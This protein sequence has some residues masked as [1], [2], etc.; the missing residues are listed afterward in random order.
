M[1]LSRNKWLFII[2]LLFSISQLPFLSRNIVSWDESVYLGI[3][4]YIYSSGSSGLWEPIRPLGLPVITGLIWKLGLPY[5]LFSQFMAFIFALASVA[6]LY[7]IAEKLFSKNVAVLAAALLVATPVFFTNSHMILTE[8]PSSFFVLLALYAFICN[9]H[10]QCGA[11]ASLAM[12]FKFTGGLVVIALFLVALHFMKPLSRN[13]RRLIPF[14]KVAVSFLAVTLP[15]MVFNS[16]F[17]HNI[18]GNL[19]NAALRPFMGNLR[20]PGESGIPRHRFANRFFGRQYL[21]SCRVE[22]TDNVYGPAE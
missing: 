3:G 12:L 15:F 9:K 1:W 7:I 17:Y 5:I 18:A 22:H 13:F 6:L 4:K 14:A 20:G 2:M 19:I 21:Y 10:Y 16:I 8:I 11:F